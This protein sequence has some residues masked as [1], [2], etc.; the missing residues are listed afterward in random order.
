MPYWAL[1]SIAK[2]E[3]GGH[4]YA[5]NIAGRGYFPKTYS[6]AAS[7]IRN[8]ASKSFD[9]GIMQVNKLWFDRLNYAYTDGLNPCFDIYLGAYVL[10][11]KIIRYGNTWKGIAA[12]HSA[13]PEQNIAYAW[14]VYDATQ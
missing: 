8:N 11:R 9:V 4:I 6:A 1:R 7:L 3:S 14:E 2:V 10:K 12:Y 13:D 5:I